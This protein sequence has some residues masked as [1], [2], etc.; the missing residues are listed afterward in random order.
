MRRRKELAPVQTNHGRT[1]FGSKVRIDVQQG[2]LANAWRSIEVQ[3]R[4]WRFGR[5]ERD[6]KQLNL[7]LAADES[8]PPTRRQPVT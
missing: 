8:V 1:R 7:G 5:L 4:N 6:P 2:R 3:Q